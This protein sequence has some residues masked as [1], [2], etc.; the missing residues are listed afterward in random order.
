M[1]KVDISRTFFRYYARKACSQ[2]YV[3]D[4]QR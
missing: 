1:L 3:Y 4:V 2:N